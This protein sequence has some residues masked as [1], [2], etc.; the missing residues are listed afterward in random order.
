LPAQAGPDGRFGLMVAAS[1]TGE[2]GKPCEEPLSDDELLDDLIPMFIAGHETTTHLI[3]N[4]MPTLLRH[5]AELTRLRGSLGHGSTL[6]C[7]A[8][9]EMLRFEG[10][11]TMI[12]RHT[13]EPFAIGDVV[14]PAGQELCCMLGAAHRDP[15]AFADLDRFDIGRQQRWTPR[16]RRRHSLLPG[17]RHWHGWRPR[18]SSRGGRN[19]TRTWS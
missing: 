9:E 15:A 12:A 6:I 18:S 1:E 8:I 4:G 19:A 5:P 2:P 10:S 3:G 16:V 14:V 13:I 17:G 11:V 7:T